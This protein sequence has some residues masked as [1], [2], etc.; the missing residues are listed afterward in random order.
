MGESIRRLWFFANVQRILTPDTRE[1]LTVERATQ[2][3]GAILVLLAQWQTSGDLPRAL[4][5]LRSEE[6]PEDYGSF[7]QRYPPGSEGD[8]LAAI[9]CSYL[10]AIG[11]LYKH[12]LFHEDLLFDW[13][14]V[15]PVWDRI[16]VYVIGQRKETTNRSLW[17]NFE[18]LATAHKRK[19]REYST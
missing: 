18:A 13:L 17:S 15:A 8:R 19:L 14:A 16:R 3:D 10:E 2:S 6:F 1:A 12:G 4:S 9:V 5:W 11:A 7:R